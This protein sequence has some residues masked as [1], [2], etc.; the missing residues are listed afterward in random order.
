MRKA[1]A[2]A[3]AMVI[4]SCTASPPPPN[5]E[6]TVPGFPNEVSDLFVRGLIIPNSAVYSRARYEQAWVD[7]A[8]AGLMWSEDSTGIDIEVL[9]FISSG[10]W[11]DS[12]ATGFAGSPEPGMWNNPEGWGYMEIWTLPDSSMYLMYRVQK[13]DRMAKIWWPKWSPS[14]HA[15]EPDSN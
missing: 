1:W 15:S 6:Q 4:S 14:Y 5:E 8:N 9:T 12:A 2:L 11:G 13:S 3:V 7:A 10:Y